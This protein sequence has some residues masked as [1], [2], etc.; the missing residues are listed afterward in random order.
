MTAQSIPAVLP[1]HGI[2][3]RQDLPVPLEFA[4][5]GAAV[6]IA[7]SFVILGLAWRSPKY[8]GAASGRTLPPP[9]TAALDSAWL[10]WTVRLFGLAVFFYTGMAL[11][12]G[13]DRLTNPIFGFVYILVWVGLVPL[14][15]L[16]GPVWRTLNP[17]RTLHLLACRVLRHNPDVGLLQLSPR[18]GLW[19]AAAGIFAFAWL[20]LVAPDRATLT[21]LQAWLSLYVVFGLFGALLFGQRWFAAADPFEA[22]ATLMAKLSPWGRRS[23]GAIVVR[24]PLENLD[25]LTPR[26]GLVGLVAALLGSTAYDG[27]SRSSYWITW[28]Q[29]TGYSEALLGTLA[30]AAFVL[31]VLITYSA[32]TVLAGRLSDSSRTALPGLFAH[33]V[34]PIVLGYVIAHYFTLL[35]LEGQR[36]LILLSDPLSNGWNVFGTGLLG[37]NAG[38][39][40]H[41]TA[42]STVQVGAVVAGHLLGVVSAHDRAVALFPR[43]RALVGQIPLLVVMVAYTVGGLLLLFSA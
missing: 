35:V 31:F 29:N 5:T 7:L 43:G 13:A 28:A 11:L 25:S 24:R 37:V 22:Y 16:L 9:V 40:N 19:P 6:A 39:T 21:V 20:E 18:V 26:P 36:T 32:A 17:L 14:S 30:L 33:S 10:R 8:R 4:V 15:L 2:G 23:D 27:F 12:A 41:S 38:I 3:G 42:V 34:V 1:L